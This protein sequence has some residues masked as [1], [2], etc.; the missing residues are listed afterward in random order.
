MFVIMNQYENHSGI[1]LIRFKTYTRPPTF[2]NVIA[3]IVRKLLSSNGNR[4][5]LSLHEYG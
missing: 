3:K 1:D 4:D 5:F 2:L